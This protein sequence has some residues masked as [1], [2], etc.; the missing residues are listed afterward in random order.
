MACSSA[1]KRERRTFTTTSLPLMVTVV[2]SGTWMVCFPIRDILAVVCTVERLTGAV[3]GFARLNL[4]VVANMLCGSV[5]CCGDDAGEGIHQRGDTRTEQSNYVHNA[6]GSTSRRCLNSHAAVRGPR[7]C[8]PI[9]S[10]PIT[11]DIHI[12][13]TR[14]KHIFGGNV[15]DTAPNRVHIDSSQQALE[16][17]RHI[18]PT[19]WRGPAKKA[20]PP[21][22]K[23]WRRRSSTD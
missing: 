9:V 3:R 6:R 10:S 12:H 2:F 7:S 4:A 15:L 1:G 8:P 23:E 19:Q 11:V 13:S 5:D 20:T 22:P 16:T 17:N 18:R 14:I 21:S